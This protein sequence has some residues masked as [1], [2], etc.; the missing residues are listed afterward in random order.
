[1]TNS[2]RQRSIEKSIKKEFGEFK[3]GKRFFCDYCRKEGENSCA[4]AYNRALYS[5]SLG[6]TTER[7]RYSWGD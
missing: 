4:K 3:C 5:K 7:E 1:M 2:D 6:T